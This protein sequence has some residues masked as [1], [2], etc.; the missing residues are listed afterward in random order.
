ML[1]FCNQPS[2]RRDEFVSEELTNHLF[3]SPGGRPFGMDLAAINVQRGRDHGLPPFTAWRTPCGLS[4]IKNWSDLEKVFAADS[5][6]R[7]K[8]LYLH[9]DDIDLFSGGLAEK[10]VR[11]GVVGPTFACIIAQQFLQ[12]RKGDRFWYEN[13]G[14]ESSFTPAQLQQIRKVSLAQILCQTLTEIETIQP[15]VFLSHD[16]FRNVRESCDNP[17]MNSF[18]LFPWAERELNNDLE[19]K[20][21]QTS[22]DKLSFHMRNARKR[23]KSVTTTTVRTPT[24]KKRKTT[25]ELPIK[26]QITNVSSNSVLVE[27]KYG[28]N[29]IP[30]R[31][32][33]IVNRPQI[34]DYNDDTFLTTPKMQKPLEVNIK[35]QYYLPTTQKTT[36]TTTRPKRKR[37]PTIYYQQPVIV[38]KK[39]TTTMSTID[40]NY[41]IF[42]TH[43]YFNERPNSR[44]T[45]TDSFYDR[46]D[47]YTTKRPYIIRPQSPYGTQ[48]EEIP[49]STSSRPYVYKP[50]TYDYLY[51]SGRP[52][53]NFYEETTRYPTFIYTNNKRPNEQSYKQ[54]QP[55]IQ[56]VYSHVLDNGPEVF[57]NGPK[58]PTFGQIDTITNTPTTEKTTQNKIYTLSHVEKLDHKQIQDKLDFKTH[59]VY[60]HRNVGQKADDE[61]RKFVKI[62]SVKAEAAVNTRNP[63]FYVVQR[64]D[65]DDIELYDD[66][67]KVLQIYKNQLKL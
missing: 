32:N 1:G 37:R 45:Y 9:V 20:N 39:P 57:I 24:T 3:Q 60:F 47:Y 46:P 52:I 29:N 53:N 49:F 10:P 66:L 30:Q 2:Q 36:T 34:N 50:N 58:K 15:F 62:S 28:S 61:K 6:Q 12:L 67:E 22:D 5:V 55:D 13:G 16:N 54:Q 65:A 8:S 18:D 43:T 35:I 4:Q 14:F 56:T 17:E 48:F 11:G 31:P 42:V 19:A 23:R 33:F 26:I 44:P 38:T 63:E 64:K 25:T 40:A 41:P 51:T 21:R 59:L 7:F 27:N